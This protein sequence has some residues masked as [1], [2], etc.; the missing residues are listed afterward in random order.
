MKKQKRKNNHL[1]G[2]DYSTN[3]YYFITICSK[4]RQ[5]IFGK[6]TRNNQNIVGTGI[7]PVPTISNLHEFG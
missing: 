2:Y 1:P 4:D 6:Y 3:G 7:A 5:N